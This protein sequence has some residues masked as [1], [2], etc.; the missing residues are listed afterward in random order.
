M[1]T[2]DQIETRLLRAVAVEP[3]E[4]GLRWLDQQVAQIAARPAVE[5]RRAFSFPGLV[6]RPVALLAAFVLLTGAVVGGISLLDQLFES[7]GM[8]G[9][10]TAWDR[11]ERLGLKQ[12]DSGITI[13]LERAYADLN[14]ALVGF[15]IEGLDVPASGDGPR[16]PLEWTAELRDPTGQSSNVW[17]RSGTGMGIDETHLAA[18]VQ[19]WE[20]PVAPVAGTWEL[21]FTSVGYGGDGF[22][23]GECDAG[24][25]DPGCINPPANT[26][27]E[28]TWR[29]AFELP[30][31]VGSILAT[32]ASAMVGDVTLSLT[33]LRISPSR[34]TARVGV[35]VDGS[36][37]AYWNQPVPSLRHGTTSYAVNA[38][39]YML[40]P[41]TG[42]AGD[43]EFQT[44]AGSDEVAGTWEMVIPEL[45]YGMTNEETVHVIGP[46]TLTVTVP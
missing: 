1:T 45:T 34:I 30:K 6:L 37:V 35:L 10:H 4:D 27:V 38:D 31:P 17:A 18:I 19:T 26:V 32:D 11:A 13:T 42:Q 3:S 24:N 29:F 46:W 22:V 41:E 15:T 21:T 20:G 14:Q 28:G 16:A 8:P 5:P 7:S 40:D 12:T 36:P 23:P 43:L 33:E 9:W 25:T 39:R 2:R 44:T